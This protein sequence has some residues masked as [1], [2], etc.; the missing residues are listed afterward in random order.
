MISEPF[1]EAA[2]RATSRATGAA[3][4]ESLGQHLRVCNN[5]TI[6]LEVDSNEEANR[7]YNALGHGGAENSGIQ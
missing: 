6:S 5:T 3:M 2:P 1:C 4:L 7:L